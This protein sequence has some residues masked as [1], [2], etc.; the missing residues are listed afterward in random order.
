MVTMQARKRGDP[1]SVAAHI[2]LKHCKRSMSDETEEKGSAAMAKKNEKSTAVIGCDIGNAYAY[3]SVARGRNVDPLSLI[4][5]EQD[6]TGI[7]SEA[8]ISRTGNINVYPINRSREARE[9]GVVHTIKRMLDLNAIPQ[10]KTDRPISPWEVYSAIARDLVRAANETLVQKGESPTYDI[11]FTYPAHLHSP[12]HLDTLNRMQESIEAVELD[13]HRIH[14]VDRLP[15]PAAAALQY[16]NFIQNVASEGV[17]FHGDELNVL[18]YD[19]GHGT[20]DLALVTARSDLTYELQD[21]DGDET[22]G[23]VDFDNAIYDELCAELFRRYQFRPTSG[24][25]EAMLRSNAAAAKLE[26]C[27]T[28][29]DHVSVEIP[30]EVDGEDQTYEASITRERFEDISS[31]LVKKTL[32]KTAALLERAENRNIRVDRIILTGGAS[33]MPLVR[34]R[35]QELVGDSF[36]IEE[37]YQPSRAVSFGAA[38]RGDKMILRR[39]TEHCYGVLLDSREDIRYRMRPMI[40]AAA[41]LPARSDP[42][43]VMPESGMARIPV[44][45]SEDGVTPCT[46]TRYLTLDG[47]P[48]GEKI[49]LILEVGEDLNIAVECRLPDGSVRRNGTGVSR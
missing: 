46:K 43:S 36:S 30:V 21:Q 6:K 33:Q 13:G 35:L 3:A 49:D 39:K 28:Q 7:P 38:L 37:P 44:V 47:L 2:L 17:R 42:L 19:L 1:N 34:R 29:N 22:V 15:E 31:P 5:S 23:G 16:L 27:T 12:E 41:Y 26:L 11:V 8:R 20:F 18:V 4:P 14:V 40:A 48:A 9:G 45:Y 32:E 10:L 24:K 25:Q